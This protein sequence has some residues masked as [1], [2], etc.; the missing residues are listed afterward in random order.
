[1]SQPH[2][3]F[4]PDKAR[5]WGEAWRDKHQGRWSGDSGRGL[6]P[7]STLPVTLQPFPAGPRPLPESNESVRAIRALEAQIRPKETP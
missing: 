5:E 4:S 3:P 1:M 7:R 6:F 2:I